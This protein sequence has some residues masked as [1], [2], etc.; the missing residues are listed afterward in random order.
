MK[1]ESFD[2]VIVGGGSAGCVLAY[3]LSADRGARVLLLEAGGPD[4]NPLLHMPAGLAGLVHNR[5]VNWHYYTEPVSGLQGRR[6]YWPRGRVLGGSSSINAMCYTRGHAQDYDEWAQLAGERWSHARVLPYFRR[7][8]NQ[9]RGADDFHGRGGPLN[10]EDLKYRNPLS[11]VFVAAGAAAGLER[12]SDF[13]AARQEGVGFYQVTQRD[14]RRCS[15]A[16][17]YLHPARHRTNLEVRTHSLAVRILF[18]RG[19]AVGVEYRRHGRLARVRAS[20]EVLLSAGAVASPQLLMLSGIGPAAELGSLGIPVVRDCAE[21]GANLQDHLDFCTLYKCRE[22]ITYDFGRMR[23]LAVALRYFLTHSGPGVSNIA[24]A[25]G[26]VRTHLAPDAR[27]DIQLHFV[28]AQLDDHG[29]NRLPGHGFTL[30]ACGLRPASRGR[31]ALRSAEPGEAPRIFPEYL[32]EPHDLEVLLEGVRLSREILHAAPFRP[33]LGV[34]VFPGEDCTTAATLE[35]VVRRKAET[36]YHPVGTCRMGSDAEA[37]VDGALRVRGVGSLRVID[38]SVMPRLIG[39]NTNAP[40]IMIA[41]LAAA[42]IIGDA[43]AVP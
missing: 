17:A 27:P 43:R 7:A 26:F 42:D 29:R 6:L 28:P 2:F 31:I 39:G 20:R 15:A 32:R 40:T 34:E 1:D 22:P 41:E 35:Q 12:N 37:V 23:E 33:Y 18:E 8:E 3:R 36:I 16:V 21:V 19:R 24:E 10:V 13:N 25:G 11:E 38:A 9:S 4:R 5:Q 14:G 30:H